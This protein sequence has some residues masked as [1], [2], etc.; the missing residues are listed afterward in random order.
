MS[1]SPLDRPLRIAG[2]GLLVAVAL[3]V[4]WS[5]VATGGSAM[6][7]KGLPREASDVGGRIE[8]YDDDTIVIS[9]TTEGIARIRIGAQTSVREPEGLADVTALLPGRLVTIWVTGSKLDGEPVARAMLV[10]GAASR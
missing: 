6:T 3:L 9:T 7:E 8:F 2:V 1:A 5:A 4:T 10:W